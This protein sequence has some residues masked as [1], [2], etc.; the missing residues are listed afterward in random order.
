MAANKPSSRAITAFMKRVDKAFGEGTF[1]IGAQP[2]PYDVISTGSAQLDDK[3]GVGGYVVGRIVEVWGQDGSGK[4][5]LAIHGMKEAQKQYPNKLVAMID[6]EHRFDLKWAALQGLD[7]ER[8]LLVRPKTAEDV[9]DQL[10]EILDPNAQ[11]FSMV[12]VDSVA[13]M[14]PKAEF[15]KA[16]DE[17]VVAAQA[18]IVTRMV[19]LASHR[20]ELSRTVVMLINQVRSSI[21]AGGPDTTTG[22]GYALKHSS[23]MKFNVR[24][25]SGGALKVNREEGGKKVPQQVGHI[26]AVRIER[27][28]VALAYRT[29]EFALLYVP[30]PEY[31]PAGFDVAREVAF[32]ARDAG[33]LDGVGTSWLTDKETGER[34]NGLERFVDHLRSDLNRMAALRKKSMDLLRDPD[35]IVYPEEIDLA[36]VEEMASTDPEEKLVQAGDLVE[37]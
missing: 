23:T 28:S 19:K 14:L 9:A 3:T 6:V 15:E 35:Q 16:A 8:F 34:F 27:N 26:I 4:T 32:L 24:R 22:G 13:A 21:G 31:G 12:V 29:A 25:A 10:K 1:V 30:T 20:A 33:L 5:T 7:L 36:R 2:V 37:S 17:A 11:L 18:K